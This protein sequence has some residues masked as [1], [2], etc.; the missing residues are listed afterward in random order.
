MGNYAIIYN[1]QSSSSKA[2]Q[3]PKSSKSPKIRIF[4]SGHKPFTYLHDPI[5]V[6][7]QTN[8]GQNPKLP[9]LHYDD[10]GDNIS[11]RNARFCE[12]TAQYW[13]WKNQSADYY[14]FFH[15]RRYLAFDQVPQ[16]PRDIWGSIIYPQLDSTA[17]QH[18][19]WDAD[20]IKRL[21]PEYDLILP[22]SRDIR[23]M[24]KMGKNLRDQYV[25]SG[26]LHTE[27]LQIMLDVLAEKYPDYLPYSQKYLAGHHTYLNNTF[28]MRRDLFEQYSAWLFDILF[29]CDR[30][31]DYSDYSTEALRTPGHLA[32]R[33]LNIYVAYLR[34]HGSYRILE[35]PTVVFLNSAPP[36]EY[37]P[38]FS[39]QN[40]A[41]VFSANEF[42][43]PYLATALQSVIVNSSPQQN[44]DCLIM[45][46]DISPATQRRLQLLIA[47]HPNFSLRFIDIS[48]YYQKFRSLFL[49]GHFTIET[50]FRLLLPELLP[51]YHKVL[52]LDADLVAET[53]LAELYATDLKGYL[54][55]ACHDA[56]T[57]GLYN[58]RG[59]DKKFYMDHIL[60]LKHPYDYFQAGVILFNLDEFRRQFTT[61]ELLAKASA[62]DWQLLDQDVLN[63]F[64]EGKVKFVDMAWNVMYNWRGTRIDEIIALA[65]KRLQD[66]YL[67]SYAHPKII[68][69]AGPDKPWHDP[70]VDLADRFWHYC[71]Q[72]NFYEIALQEMVK[73]SR[74][75]RLRS[76]IK[77]TLARALPADT[78]LGATARRLYHR[79]RH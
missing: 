50:W 59:S 62:Y 21:V 48:P 44:Y 9:G 1:M 49:R 43:A 35:L 76:R 32:E 73:H 12:L 28:I 41:I 47:N 27:D 61:S 38:A 78:K 3:S 79:L 23:T 15:Y 22:E 4:I 2:H 5:F 11:N 69:Y 64:A 6:P 13:A 39:K 14:G 66:A 45:H 17:V 25:G 29:E 53:D 8:A 24:P 34:D 30:R 19:H 56:D 20:T 33:L 55:A 26:F 51:H 75:P 31:I 46:R 36:A 60:K 57:A 70:A 68:H 65:P 18:F 52:Y 72:T 7:V 42:Y 67:K 58:E 37:L 63:F 74:T 77:K 10:S 16:D 40:N 54:L 71:R